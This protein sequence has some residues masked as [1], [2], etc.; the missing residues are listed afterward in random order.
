M[1]H[2]FLPLQ[3]LNPIV[4]LRHHYD[5]YKRVMSHEWVMSHMKMNHVLSSITN[6]KPNGITKLCN[7]FTYFILRFRVCNK[8]RTWFVHK[9]VI[10]IENGHDSYINVWYTGRYPCTAELCTYFTNQILRFRVCNRGKDMIHIYVWHI[11][12]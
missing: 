7:H 4:S 12:R 3:N 6:P 5:A 8:K 11:T 10:L 2:I 9:C 1:N